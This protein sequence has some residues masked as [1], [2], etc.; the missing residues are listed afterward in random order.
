MPGE[1]ANTGRFTRKINGEKTK[2]TNAK[3][4]TLRRGLDGSFRR[5]R[6]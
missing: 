3:F 5:R 2:F 1:L 6:C 4:E